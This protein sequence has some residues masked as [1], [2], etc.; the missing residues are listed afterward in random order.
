MRF[1]MTP[2]AHYFDLHDAEALFGLLRLV[3]NSISSS[4]SKRV[5][6]FL[7]LVFGLTH[8]REWIAPGYDPQHTATTPAEQ[9]FQHIYDLREFRI[10][11]HLCN[12]SKHMI[13]AKNAMGTLY[14]S[15]IDDWPN[16]DA[17]RDFDRGFPTAY[18]VDDQDALE[19]IQTVIT[20]YD[21]NWFQV[22]GKHESLEK[23]RLS[24]GSDGS[25]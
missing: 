12:R 23:K 15:T 20:F 24:G 14:E 13:P 22:A 7:F 16:V 21:K 19:V 9:F 3:A 4:P 8:L 2:P 17:V 18:S 1:Q 11:Q 10:L 5:Q 6:D 25:T